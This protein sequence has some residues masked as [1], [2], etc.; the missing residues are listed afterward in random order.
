MNHLIKIIKGSLVGMGS[1]LP[2]VS[3]SMIAAVLNIYQDLIEALNAFTKHPIQSIVKV[4]QY[5]VGVFV[6]LGLGFIFISTF[7]DVAPIPLS[8]LFIGF[9]I[10]AIPGLKKEI[11]SDNT[12]VSNGDLEVNK[13]ITKKIEASAFK[14]VLASTYQTAYR[15]YLITNGIK[16]FQPFYEETHP[17][18]FINCGVK[19][20]AAVAGEARAQVWNVRHLQPILRKKPRFI[21]RCSIT[22]K[23]TN[24]EVYK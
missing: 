4:W 15:L 13:F 3:G 2:G 17:D 14:T 10:G 21:L 8:L 5:I 1:I 12:P 23:K 24:K 7:L 9:I 18:Y 6:G 20:E 22:E 11:K 19:T 16:E